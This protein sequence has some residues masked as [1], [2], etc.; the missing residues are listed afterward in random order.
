MITRED[1]QPFHDTCRILDKADDFIY[2]LPHPGLLEWISNYTITFPN[3]NIISDDYTVMPHGSATLVFTFDGNNLCSNLFGPITKPRMIGRQANQNDMLFI[4]EFQPAGL[5]AY[6]GVDQR[7]LSDQTLPF[8][9]INPV[10][11]KKIMETLDSVHSMHELVIHIDHILLSCLPLPRPGELHW[12]VESIIRNSGNISVKELSEAVYYSERHLNRIFS[13][14]LGMNTKTFS[15]L[16]RIN[17]A[18]RLLQNPGTSISSVCYSAGFY[19]LSHFIHD[20]K[21]VTGITPL[22][23]RHKMSDFYSEI[24]K[25]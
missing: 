13:R 11:N 8:S 24:A 16:V 22:D 9:F 10:L 17:K 23:Y 7:E 1:R 6:T 21:D 2:V 3:G 12:S 18:V 4:I 15:R 19:D 14:Y 5:H 25:F 20:F